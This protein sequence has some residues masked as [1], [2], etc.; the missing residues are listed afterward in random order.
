MLVHLYLPQSVVLHRHRLFMEQLQHTLARWEALPAQ[1]P[2]I[3]AVIAARLS[4]RVRYVCGGAHLLAALEAGGVVHSGQNA[5]PLQTLP[6][7]RSLP[8]RLE[9]DTML[10]SAAPPCAPAPT[11][12]HPQLFC[13]AELARRRPA[14][15]LQLWSRKCCPA[16][17]AGQP[18][19]P[20]GKPPLHEALQ[21]TAH[22]LGEHLTPD[23]LAELGREWA[24]YQDVMARRREAR[25]AAAADLQYRAA[26]H[27]TSWLKSGTLA[28]GG[29][30]AERCEV[31]CGDGQGRWVPGG[32]GAAVA[33][34][35]RPVRLQSLHRALAC[36][37]RPSS[38]TAR[39]PCVPAP[40]P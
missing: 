33:T 13:L 22:Y 5:C 6:P 35:K 19:S 9:L 2:R 30:T 15:L 20:D 1:R 21:P 3:E 40:P 16:A 37:P 11:L 27:S 31:R 10:Q 32:G 4:D 36:P 14:D 17:P 23:Q 29:S 28:V 24:A 34:C 12:P 26:L 8:S 7:H 25:V 18:P 38:S 39:L